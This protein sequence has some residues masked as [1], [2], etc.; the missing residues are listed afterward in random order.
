MLW[1]RS[2]KIRYF[3]TNFGAYSAIAVY[4]R[5]RKKCTKAK[6][7][8]ALCYQSTKTYILVKKRAWGFQKVGN[9]A[10]LPVFH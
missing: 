6:T 5:L 2:K 9:A 1:F 10:N 4:S 3:K 7:K 8:Q